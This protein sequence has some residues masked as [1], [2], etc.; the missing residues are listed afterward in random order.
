MSFGIV[1][2]SLSRSLSEL[3][4]L[5]ALACLVGLALLALVF[6]VQGKELRR[7]QEWVEQLR[8]TP[9]SQPRPSPQV[10]VQPQRRQPA[11]VQSRPAAGQIPPL[12]PPPP[13][14]PQPPTGQADFPNLTPPKHLP[15]PSEFR[16]LREEEG[17]WRRNLAVAAVAAVA[18]GLAA[19]LATGGSGG[20]TA[21]S[22]TTST[23]TTAHRS[24]SSGQ[25]KA[26]NTQPGELPVAVLNPTEINGLAHRLAA[27]LQG[28]GYSRAQALDGRPPGTYTT[29]V[30]E[31][32]PGYRQ[33]AERL[34]RTLALEGGAV[35]P[36][37]G[38]VAALAG[39]AP[40]VVIASGSAGEETAPPP[41]TGQVGEG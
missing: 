38:S 28:D 6:F 5:V 12:P 36:L 37:E 24:G 22:T 14:R 34:A 13:S 7:L 1:A 25:P 8:R 16:F 41:T 20:Q 10:A 39:G 27:Q 32:Q 29:T 11:F 15:D 40:V 33:A 21:G 35:R 31:Y 4:A 19:F 30:V 2:L 26:Q 3:G 17:G 18:V 23:A 9:Q